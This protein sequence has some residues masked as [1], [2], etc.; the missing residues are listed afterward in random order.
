VHVAG[1]LGDL[2]GRRTIF[3]TGLVVFTTASLACGLAASREVLIGSRL[4][5]GAGERSPR[6]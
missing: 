2:I 1:R 3:L 5:Q 4:L 6:A